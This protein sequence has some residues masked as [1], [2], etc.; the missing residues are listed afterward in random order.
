MNCNFNYVVVSEYDR[1][2]SCFIFHKSSFVERERIQISVCDIKI[3]DRIL[4]NE[5]G[6]IYTIKI[7]YIGYEQ[8]KPT[9]FSG[10]SIV[11]MQHGISKKVSDLQIGDI[12]L[13]GDLNFVSVKCILKTIIND[14][15]DMCTYNG[16]EI[17]PYHPILINNKWCFPFNTDNFIIINKYI[18]A[19]YSIGLDNNSSILINNIH[20][21]ALN[22][23]ITD[24]NITN[25]DYFGT[26]KVINDI[27]NLSSN[28]YCI[29]E[30]NQIKRNKITGLIEKII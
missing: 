27:F 2:T 13:T 26:A 25:H 15:I 10:E 1:F 23:G 8:Y 28:G 5:N 19:V 12:I 22:H 6:I 18:E 29:I 3:G 14:N 20:V 24:N 7:N 17:T 9:C 11:Q 4:F 30:L 21:I 16:L